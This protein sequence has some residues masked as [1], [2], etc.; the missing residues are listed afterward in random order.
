MKRKLFCVFTILVIITVGSLSGCGG[1]GCQGDHRPY[2]PELEFNWDE[3]EG[4]STSTMLPTQ[5][6]LG[7]PVYDENL[8][9]SSI[10]SSKTE[11]DGE[12]TDMG[13][14]YS[15]KDDFQTVLSWYKDTLG[16]PSETQVL[17]NGHNQAW[18][19]LEKDGNSIQVIITCTDEGTAISVLTAKK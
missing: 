9:P 16:E 12:V 6:E 10:E 4:H 14:D 19:N 15:T 18:W 13:V 7:V 8:D 11:T 17:S 3:T 5:D 1:C 2:V